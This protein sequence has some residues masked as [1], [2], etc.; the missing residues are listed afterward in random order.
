MCYSEERNIEDIEKKLDFSHL[1][2]C[3]E[4]ESGR[5]KEHE[6]TH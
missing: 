1:S 2:E 4:L 5:I 3:Y 6:E